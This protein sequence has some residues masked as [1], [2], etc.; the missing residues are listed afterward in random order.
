M[1]NDEFVA[2]LETVKGYLEWEM[3]LNFIIALD[4]VIKKTKQKKPSIAKSTYKCCSCGTKLR[5][6]SNISRRIRD[7]YCPKCGQAIDWS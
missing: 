7:E 1:T 6:G 2:E 5:P 3:P 4:K